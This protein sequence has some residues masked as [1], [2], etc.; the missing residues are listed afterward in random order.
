MTSRPETLI[1]NFIVEYEA[2][3]RPEA[4]RYARLDAEHNEC[5][6]AYDAIIFEIENGFFSPSAEALEGIKEIAASMG[7]EYPKLSTNS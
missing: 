4:V 3:L 2:Q 6:L 1:M 7:I 5:G